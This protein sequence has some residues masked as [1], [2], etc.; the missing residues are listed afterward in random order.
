MTEKTEGQYELSVGSSGEYED[1]I[2]EITFGHKF[3]LVISQ[4]RSEGV[5]E[6]SVHS[7][8]KDS[9]H[10]FAYGKNIEDAKIPLSLLTEAIE[11][12]VSELK[13]L[14]RRPSNTP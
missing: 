8:R 4:E 2:A 10:A 9:E 12:A 11:R 7:F 3:G 13:R 1:L 6:I 5:F 14:R